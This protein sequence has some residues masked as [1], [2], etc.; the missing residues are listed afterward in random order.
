MKRFRRVN[1]WLKISVFI[2]LFLALVWRISDFLEEVSVGVIKMS[3]GPY[4]LN[5][6]FAVLAQLLIISL[7]A[8]ILYIVQKNI[9]RVNFHR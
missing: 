6:N 3:I 8:A 4:H 2:T 1:F 7:L 5:G 9:Y